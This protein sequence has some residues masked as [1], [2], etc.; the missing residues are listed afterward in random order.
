M[1][2][3]V[4]YG[5]G[6]IGSMQNMLRHI[7]ILSKLESDPLEISKAQKLI[8]PGVGSFD[9]A[10]KEITNIPGLLNVLNHKAKVE[11]IP[12]LGICLGMQLMTRSSEE[13]EKKG[14]GWIKADTKRFRL[15]SKFKVPHMGWNNV[16]VNSSTELTDLSDDVQRFYFVH[17]YY[18]KV[19]HQVN[20][21]FKTKYGLI[22]F[23]SGIVDQN[24]YGVQ[25]HPEKSHKF[26]MNLFQKFANI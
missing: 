22:E 9:I 24:I 10:M 1:I 25:F 17:S 26:G 15:N 19:D 5:L 16:E 6:N 18:V 23:D 11:K 12:I 21:M 7:G 20:S 2:T 13:G 14:L 4:N 3:I 8:L